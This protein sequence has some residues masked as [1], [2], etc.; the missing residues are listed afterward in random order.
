MKRAIITPKAAACFCACVFTHDALVSI[1]GSKRLAG[2]AE[3]FTSRT[4]G[5][6]TFFVAGERLEQTLGGKA[7][8]EP[9]LTEK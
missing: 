2:V 9:E 4:T 1:D 8:D 7:S 6:V 5:G 3:Q